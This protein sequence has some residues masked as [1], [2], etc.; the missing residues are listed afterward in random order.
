[1]IELPP[2]FLNALFVG[3][4]VAAQINELIGSA[5]SSGFRAGQAGANP[6]SAWLRADPGSGA[7]S[8]VAMSGIVVQK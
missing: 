7:P 2:W 8:D 4:I 6:L 5:V 1:M 3:L